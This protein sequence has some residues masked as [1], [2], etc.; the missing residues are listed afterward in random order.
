MGVRGRLSAPASPVREM[1]L[2]SQNLDRK[3][4]Q[5]AK[6]C[7]LV[8][9]NL[10]SRGLWRTA[11]KV[12]RCN[13]LDAHDNWLIGWRCGITH[14]PR[15][16][17]A[18]ARKRSNDLQRNYQEALLTHKRMGFFAFT[19]TLADT[20]LNSVRDAVSALG[21]GMRSI[22]KTI[23]HYRGSYWQIEVPPSEITPGAANVH[24][25]GALLIPN[26]EKPSVEDIHDHW[27]SAFGISARSD[28]WEPVENP[29]GW[30]NYCTKPESLYGWDQE[31]FDTLVGQLASQKMRG[32]LN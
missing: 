7:D 32:W 9:N 6:A 28:K 3:S 8:I 29:S 12:Q 19:G 10:Q 13:S 14:C 26:K 24:A 2:W 15:C 31:D 17:W 21:K 25:H 27:Q 30:C 1:E 16:E 23:R 5:K 20:A 11:E 22:F 4:D 18:I